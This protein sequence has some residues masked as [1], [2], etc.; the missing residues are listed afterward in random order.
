MNKLGYVTLSGR[1]RIDRLIADAVAGLEQSGLRL[2]GTVQTNIERADGR[3]CDMDLRLMPDGG[4]VRI[5]LNRGPEAR[6][7]RLNAD[8]LEQSVAW[9]SAHL[10]GAE[11]LVINKFGKMEAEGRGLRQSI[12][13]AM[14]LN[15]PVLV[16]VNGLNL[17]A[18]LDF[19]GELAEPIEP[20]PNAVIAWCLAACG[21]SLQAAPLAEGM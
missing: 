6:G 21:R 9:V 1:G 10:E 20:A 8:A 11:L 17:P 7:C 12:A 2:V 19:A 18:F 14:D 5:S 15:I 13:R 4:D 3:T 16:G